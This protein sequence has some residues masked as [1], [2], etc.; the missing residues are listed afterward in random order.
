MVSVGCSA[1]MRQGGRGSE[2][3]VSAVKNK[4][5]Q[6]FIKRFMKYLVLLIVLICMLIPLVN[7]SKSYIRDIVVQ[8]LTKSMQESIDMVEQ[9]FNKAQQMMSILSTEESFQKLMKDKGKI[10]LEHYVYLL[11]LQTKLTQ[12]NALFDLD[13]VSYLV[14]RNSPILISN[15]GS[16]DDYSTSMPIPA[17]FADQGAEKWHEFIFQTPYSHQI[18]PDTEFVN[19]GSSKRN[20]GIVFIIDTMQKGE[21][22][23]NCKLVTLVDC[24]SVIDRVVNDNL[25]QNGF[26]YI[27]DESGQL[28]FQHNYIDDVS[29]VD[30]ETGRN[31]VIN[32]VHYQ[33]FESGS[34]LWGL[35]LVYGMLDSAIEQKVQ[36]SMA[37][38]I[39]FCIA[40]GVGTIVIVS[41]LFSVRETRSIR[42]LINTAARSTHSEYR[43]DEYSFLTNAF[44]TLDQ[45]NVEK[46][47][48]INVLNCQLEIS[49]LK[50]LIQ[51]G[52]YAVKGQP[53]FLKYFGGHFE[54]FCVTIFS[55][56]AA[57]E[58]LSLMEQQQIHV[59]MEEIVS[60]EA[61]QPDYYYCFL[62]INPAELVC[63]LSLD[64]DEPVDLSRVRNRMLQAMKLLNDQLDQEEWDITVCAG[65]SKP[66]YDITNARIA[67]L[68]AQ[69][70]L[71]LED[72]IHSGEVYQYAAPQTALLKSTFESVR[73]QH[74]YDMLIRGD[75]EAVRAFFD[76]LDISL[77]RRTFG[78][79]EIMQ[80]FFN[81]RQPVYNAYIQIL[82]NEDA[83]A[84]NE[85]QAFPE[86][87]PG[88]T[89]EQIQKDY[90]GFCLLLCDIVEKKRKNYNDA[91]SRKILEYIQQHFTDSEL[92]AVQI[93][94]EFLISEKYLYGVIKEASGKTFG[95]YIESMRMKE[96]ESLLLNT[97]L[98]NIQIYQQCGFGSENTFYR[99]FLKAHGMSPAA[100]KVKMHTE[101]G[102]NG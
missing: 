53:D 78:D 7:I 22:N 85:L 57:G 33:I 13:T 23:P 87:V 81:L 100:W 12:L 101:T 19:P 66:A 93:A 3:D 97:E 43:R 96:A 36:K 82:S 77:A 86:Y 5:Y 56:R 49:I 1:G 40:L 46:Q 74:C 39:S 11:K 6:L 17:D 47:E 48:Q 18:L 60:R 99:N 88:C 41:L 61:L 4:L 70:A 44:Q 69:N 62:V 64:K 10:P 75:K 14:F 71:S 76:D 95:K 79:Q 25:D 83:Q 21:I 72:E 16:F 98:T 38:W 68:Q 54:F 26:L 34:Q 58:R 29:P 30:A 52:G 92:T 59:A 51:Y 90:V 91:N 50:S 35:K 94:E 67:Y 84:V 31:A 9:N 102:K 65:I 32:G 24:S 28:L 2:R 20:H 8:N 63:V 55:V 37:H 27:T 15:S 89:A 42:A 45:S 73:F 80:L